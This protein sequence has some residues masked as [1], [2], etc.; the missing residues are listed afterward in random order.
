MGTYHQLTGA[1]SPGGLLFTCE[2]DDCG[3]RLVIDRDR[4]EMVVIDHG[5]PFALHQG[6]VGGVEMSPPRVVPT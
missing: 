5:D 2:E 6:V 1:I 3:R 4:G